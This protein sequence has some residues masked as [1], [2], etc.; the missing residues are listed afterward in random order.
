[1]L[2]E[3]QI[4]KKVVSFGNG[5]IVYTPKNWIGREV[6]IT[7]PGLSLKEE[8]LDL[9]KPYL[10]NIQGVYLYG[11]Y[12]RNEQGPDSDIDILVVS[13]K[14]FS[15]QKDGYDISVHNLSSLKKILEDNPIYSLIL[16][17]AKVIL[18]RYLLVDL[19][20]NIKS[21]K[22]D[23]SFI[24]ETTEDILEINKD[25]IDL[26]S[27]EFSN[28]AVIYSLVLRLRGLYMIDCILKG[29]KYFN[30]D[31]KKF[32][33]G[34]GVD[35]FNLFYSIYRNQRDNKRVGKIKIF[36]DDVIKLYSLVKNEAEKK[37]IKIHRQ[38]S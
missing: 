26:E 2:I 37:S 22:Q 1:M 10:E 11:S 23:F 33:I 17:E 14:K 30:K 25:M 7:L 38:L 20:E 15:I 3:E 13:D 4:K 28:Y 5:S 6:I 29:R 31:F 21:I 27:E 12:A 36:K 34:K 8:I 19:L 24:M 35:K 16:R 32:A 9:L 18:N